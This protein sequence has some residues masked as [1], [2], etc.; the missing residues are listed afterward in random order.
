MSLKWFRK[1]DNPVNLV[2]DF[3]LGLPALAWVA[4]TLWPY[5]VRGLK[6]ISGVP[7]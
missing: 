2:F 6:Y 3:L 7:S 1:R 5:L 4:Y